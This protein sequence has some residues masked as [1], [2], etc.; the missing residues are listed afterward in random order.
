MVNTREHKNFRKPPWVLQFLRV[1]TLS[2]LFEWKKTWDE[3]PENPWNSQLGMQGF[4]ENTGLD[5]LSKGSTVKGSQNMFYDQ[6]K[7][8][9][10]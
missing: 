7:P 6:H 9:A 5:S 1:N 4:L 3:S 2:S 8:H 10:E